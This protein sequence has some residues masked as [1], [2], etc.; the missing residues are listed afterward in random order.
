VSI[1]NKKGYNENAVTPYFITGAEGEI[2]TPTRI[3]PLDPEFFS[4]FFVTF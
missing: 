3:P 4:V 1:K 2:R